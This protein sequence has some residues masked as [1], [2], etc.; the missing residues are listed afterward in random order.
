MSP[1]KKT[2]QYRPSISDEAVKAKTGKNWAKWFEVLDRAKAV[3]LN[4]TEISTF[5]YHK[6]HCPGWWCEMVAVEYERTR[7]LRK[8]H[9]TP[10]GFQGSV[11]K[12]IHVPI[13]KLF[14]AWSDEKIRALWLPKAPMTIRTARLNKSI[15]VAWDGEVSN[16]DVRF[17]AVGKG[18]S[19][20]AVDRTKMRSAAEVARMKAFWKQRL[21]ALATLLAP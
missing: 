13:A 20:V 3:T 15:R 7:G 17:T 18:K 2:A 6:Q 12:T 10:S 5:L 21:E 9:E 1:T 19:Q 11:S 8:I 4:H 16:I 14:K